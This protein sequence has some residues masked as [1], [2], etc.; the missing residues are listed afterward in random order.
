MIKNELEEDL[1]AVIDDAHIQTEKKIVFFH[2]C[3]TQ[4]NM[5]A[6][7]ANV[8]R[9]RWNEEVFQPY[10]VHCATNDDQVLTGT[11]L[12]TPVGDYLEIVNGFTQRWYGR[13]GGATLEQV[14]S[15]VRNIELAYEEVKDLP[16][17][18][19]PQ[20]RMW[21]RKVKLETGSYDF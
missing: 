7:V 11:V 17:F 8:V 14:A 9:K 5:G 1:F 20:L 16:T 2:G 21:L 10:R 19:A 18:L 15:C 3:N 6:G 13:R 12:T 4:G